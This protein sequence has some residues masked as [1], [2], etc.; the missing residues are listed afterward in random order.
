MRCNRCDLVFVDQRHLPESDREKSR[1]DL[2]ENTPANEGYKNFLSRII[3]PLTKHLNKQATGLDFGCGPTPVLASMLEDEDFKMQIYD[4][5]YFP[6]ESVLNRTYDFITLTEVAEHFH[7]PQKEFKRLIQL[8]NPQGVIAIMTQLRVPSID[9]GTWFYKNDFTHVCFYSPTTIH[10]IEKTYGF[11][12]E[13]ILPDII[14][15]SS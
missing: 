15:L 5:F 10:W 6:N 1:Y 11:K 7:H 8:L 13:I 14:L 9:F 4:P 2:H 3:A 12:T